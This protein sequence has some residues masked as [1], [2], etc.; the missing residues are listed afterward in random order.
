MATPWGCSDA[1]GEL[2]CH[3]EYPRK[4]RSYSGIRSGIPRLQAVQQAS[5]RPFQRSW[6]NL[7]IICFDDTLSD[8]LAVDGQ[9]ELVLARAGH[10]QFANAK[11]N[12]QLGDQAILLV[13]QIGGTV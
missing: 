12:P 13:N 5:L 9:R 2:S 11:M 4:H 7:P 1:S 10:N 8:K 3:P 6:L